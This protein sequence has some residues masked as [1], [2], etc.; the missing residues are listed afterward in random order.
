MQMT[1]TK[2][3]WTIFID[4]SIMAVLLL[5]GQVLR[6]KLKIFQ[7]LLIPSALIAGFLALLLGPKG[8]NI[9]P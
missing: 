1:L 3:I 2:A 6:A 9:I 5:I 7:K 8:Y 4:I